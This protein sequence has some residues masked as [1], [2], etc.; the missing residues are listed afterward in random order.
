M[1]KE[2]SEFE[3][4]IEYR[5]VKLRSMKKRVFEATVFWKGK[6]YETMKVSKE[7]C[8]EELKRQAAIHEPQ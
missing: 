6:L 3:S 1:V 2:K 8:A 7:L 4:R 5:R